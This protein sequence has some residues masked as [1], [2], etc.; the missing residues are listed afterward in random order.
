MAETSRDMT[1]SMLVERILL[2]SLERT[3]VKASGL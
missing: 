2:Y 3:I 1:D